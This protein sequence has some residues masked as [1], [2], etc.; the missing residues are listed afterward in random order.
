[1]FSFRFVSI[2]RCKSKYDADRHGPTI[3]LEK[4]A[5][6]GFL[7]GDFFLLFLCDPTDYFFLNVILFYIVKILSQIIFFSIH[8]SQSIFSQNSTSDYCSSSNR[9]KVPWLFSQA[10]PLFSH[11]TDTHTRAHTFQ[12]NHMICVLKKSNSFVNSFLSELSL[13]HPIS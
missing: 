6:L 5:G 9:G 13:F 3:Y 12:N 2:S 1:M 10:L 4:G 11:I 7:F 8:P